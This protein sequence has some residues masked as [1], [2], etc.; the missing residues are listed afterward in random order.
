[1][2]KRNKESERVESMMGEKEKPKKKSIK[3]SILRAVLILLI[4]A[5]VGL[6]IFAEDYYRPSMIAEEALI[7]GGGITFAEEDGDL[8]FIPENPIGGVVLYPG[9]QVSERAYGHLGRKMAEAGYKTVIL[10]VPFKLSILA[11]Q[12]AKEYVGKD[13]LPWVL[14]GHSLGGV[15]AARFTVKNPEAVEALILLASYPDGGTTLR[16]LPVAVYSL[17][18]DKDQIID[19]VKLREAEERLPRNF[20]GVLIRGGNHSSFGN[21]GVQK[22]DALPDITFDEQQGYILDVLAEIF[23]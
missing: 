21:Y 16:G 7:S 4:F 15:S 17:L 12:G 9:G 22:G 3:D 10:K 19:H 8:L 1:M 14:M 5:G 6:Y 11:N 18:G 13:D 2:M 20:T 23:Q